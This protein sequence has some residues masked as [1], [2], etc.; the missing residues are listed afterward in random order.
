M[1]T[2]PSVTIL[3]TT[4]TALITGK[5]FCHFFDNAVVLLVKCAVVVDDG[6]SN[7]DQVENSLLER[8]PSVSCGEGSL[9]IHVMS[10]RSLSKEVIV[11]VE[12]E[13][14]R[15]NRTCEQKL[16]ELKVGRT[17]E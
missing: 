15:K 11:L 10:L 9:I 17:T 2:A 7:S 16:S 3:V 13:R 12:R 4:S 1:N 5:C 8:S 6:D 14:G